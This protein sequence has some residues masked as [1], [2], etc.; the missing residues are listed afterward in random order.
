MAQI[1]AKMGAL[2]PMLANMQEMNNNMIGMQ[3]SMHR[4]QC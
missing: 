2:K 1:N 3:K 4:Y